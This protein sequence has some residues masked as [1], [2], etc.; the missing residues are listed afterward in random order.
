[1]IGVLFAHCGSKT[2][3][4]MCAVALIEERYFHVM[5]CQQSGMRS[6]MMLKFYVKTFFDSPR[7]R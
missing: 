6:L 3:V 2:K 5:E 4:L 1:M 7:C